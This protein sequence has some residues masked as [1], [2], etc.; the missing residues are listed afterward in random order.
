MRRGRF[1]VLLVLS[2]AL[3]G[4][5]GPST[6][7]W[8]ADNGELHVD[9]SQE[10]TTVSSGL[11]PENTKISNI[12]GIGCAPG[13]GELG[14]D[15]TDT[16]SF[17][18]Y[19]GASQFYSSHPED[20]GAVEFDYGV[21]T[22]VAIQNMPLDDANNIVDGDG[23]RID[24]KKWDSPLNPETGTGSVDLDE[25]DRDSDT[26]WYI[27]GLIPTSENIHNGLTALD[28]WH[29]S[30]TINGYLVQTN[31]SGNGLGYYNSQTA[32]VDCNLAI[33]TQNNERLYV[34]VTSIELEGA[35]ISSN[36]E[37]SDEW[38]YGDV[39]IFGRTGY[40]LFFLAFG[41]GGGF[42]AFILS[43]MFVLQGAKSTMKNL[44][45][46]AG[47]DSIKQ[48]KQDVKSAKAAGL[49]SPT[50]RK[51]EGRKHA[52]TNKPQSTAEEPALAGFDLDSVLSS[53]PSTGSTI[54]FGGGS[55]SV[56]ETIESQE[57][58]RE[59]SEQPS[60]IP[61]SQRQS[62]FP[63][64]ESGSRVTSPQDTVPQR[65]HFTSA[66]PTKKSAPSKKKTV[67]KR[68]A[69]SSR[70]KQES[71]LPEAEP[72]VETRDAFEE[73]EEDFSDFSF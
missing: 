12:E 8:G 57:M 5:L 41:I 42:G 71:V 11:G 64:R 39:P 35:T 27:L 69:T 65:E 13:S 3:A 31:S 21:A 59:I 48:V 24:I 20:G 38:V 28:E 18:G 47:M 36:G 72:K 73:P 1:A 9:F 44:L 23:P 53:G 50:E 30:V 4:C 58:D 43:K 26:K 14:E 15:N 34:L 29:Q 40:L 33:G 37:A 70:V 52:S 63:P 17:S 45:G 25:L 46:K 51:K 56:V 6:A 55:S 16:V 10:S 49:V 22:S 62:P 68:K 60:A 32:D 54:E 7:S 19:L 2:M 61:S 67:R 66:A